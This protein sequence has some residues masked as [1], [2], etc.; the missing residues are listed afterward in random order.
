MIWDR[1]GTTRQ[2]HDLLYIITKCQINTPWIEQKF[3]ITNYAWIMCKG[4]WLRWI[5][6]SYMLAK[7]DLLDEAGRDR[8]SELAQDEWIILLD[9]FSH[10][11]ASLSRIDYIQTGRYYGLTV[12][13]HYQCLIY[14]HRSSNTCLLID[15]NAAPPRA[16]IKN[17]VRTAAGILK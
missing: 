9:L 16:C 3:C 13:I 8:T 7:S 1:W 10:R 17:K 15:T 2:M 14:L 11:L 12:H 6:W 5:L 4:Y